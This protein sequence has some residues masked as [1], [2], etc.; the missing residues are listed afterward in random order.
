M[1]ARVVGLDGRQVQLATAED[2]RR[3]G[4]MTREFGLT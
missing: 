2:V 3:Q 4:R 1:R